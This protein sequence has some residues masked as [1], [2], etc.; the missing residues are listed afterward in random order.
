[1]ASSPG[2]WPLSWWWCWLLVLLAWLFGR[3]T[4]LAQCPHGSARGAGH[5]D[6]QSGTLSLQ[7]GGGILLLDGQTEHWFA[8]DFLG[9]SGAVPSY[10]V[11]GQNLDV[12]LREGRRRTWLNTDLVKQWE[13]HL[14]PHLRWDLELESGA[15]DGKIN[16]EGVRLNDVRLK[17]GAGDMTVRL[18]DNGEMVKM[19]VE[20]GAANLKIQV[21]EDTG[22]SIGIKGVLANSNL[23]ELGW[24]QVEGRYRSPA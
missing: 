24:P 23:R 14:S 20:A 10:S 8:G 13:V 4:A 16:L 7:F 21:P 5:P 11:R 9:T 6:L 15:V 3:A 2:H 19:R 1:M 12:R 18:G 17:L 22:V